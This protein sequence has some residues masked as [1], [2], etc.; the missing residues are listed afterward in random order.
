MFRLWVTGSP[1]SGEASVSS[2][3]TGAQRAWWFPSNSNTTSHSLRIC[4]YSLCSALS[5]V[6]SLW[7]LVQQVTKSR[8]Q[9]LLLHRSLC[10]ASVCAFLLS[11][12][13]F[14]LRW[15]ALWEYCVNV[16]LWSGTGRPWSIGHLLQRPVDKASR[17]C[18][19]QEGV[20]QCMKNISCSLFL[21]ASSWPSE[22]RI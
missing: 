14:F 17:L 21:V 10:C 16:W 7:L 11:L 20:L 3:P 19:P 9:A 5:C 22:V 12:T 8:E 1:S 4:V 18:E 13:L 6:Y 2:R 15:C